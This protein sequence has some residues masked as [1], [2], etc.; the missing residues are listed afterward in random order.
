MIKTVFGFDPGLKSAIGVISV[1]GNNQYLY[2]DDIPVDNGKIDGM[3]LASIIAFQVECVLRFHTATRPIGIDCII[4]NVHTMPSQGISSSGKFMEAYGT[5]QGV[6]NGMGMEFSRV[7]PQKWK[8]LYW[9]K[10]TKGDKYASLE[11]ARELFPEIEH[12]LKRKKDHNRA[13]AL[14]LAHY[15]LKMGGG[16]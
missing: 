1:S 14:L 10:S 9:D 15:G 16:E 5:I 4:E 12:L 11:K 13:E 3:K 2:A 6:L 8:K 7:T